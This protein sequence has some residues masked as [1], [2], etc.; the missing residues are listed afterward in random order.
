MT[1][2]DIVEKFLAFE[3]KH[4]HK[5]ISNVS[6][7]PENDPTLLYVNSGMFPLVPYLQG[8]PHPLGKR[9][10]NVQRALRFFEDLDNVG[11]TNRHTTAFHMLGNWSLGDYFKEEQLTWYFEFLVETLGLDI[12]KMYASIFAGDIDAPKDE[13][14]M[15]VLKR[16]FAKYGVSA[17]EGERIFAY[18]KKDNWWKRGEAVG[19]L[20]GPDSEVFYY[21]GESGDGFG[22]NPVENQNDFL[23][24]GNSVFMQY[25]KTE[26]GWEELS[27]KNVDFG[28]GL[29]R[30]ALVLQNKRDIFET[31]NFWPII[32][33][34][35]IMSGKKY[36]VEKAHTKAMRVL[37]DHMR[38][39]VFM[40][41]DGVLPSNREQG[42][43]LRR[44]L[45]RMTRAGMV[46]GIDAKV[47]LSP[48][49]VG[50][51]AE[52]FSWLY[53]DLKNK[54]AL[55][56]KIFVEEESRFE[57]VLVT[58]KREVEKTLTVFTGNCGDLVDE[59]FNLYQSF[60]YPLEIFLEDVN[61]RGIEVDAEG[62][63]IDFKA[64]IKKHQ[65]M[66]REGASQKF[67]GGLADH[68]DEVI[69]YHTVT[70]LLHMALRQV[71]GAGIIQKGSNIT[72]ERLRFDFSYD[73][74]LTDEQI[75]QVEG[76][77]RN[78][79]SKKLPVGFEIMSKT[80]AEKVGALHA[81]DEKYGD[82]VKVY[83]IGEGLHDAIS[84]EFCG[85][86]HVNNTQELKS[87]SVYK[88]KSV[89]EGLQRIYAR[90][91]GLS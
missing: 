6:L 50:V 31:D 88:Q 15:E 25:K 86:P 71:L 75:E 36:G 59:A 32:E 3:K 85:G 70:H 78:A 58:G 84:K 21:I 19:E 11:E 89:G 1:S 8:E 46:L 33:Q 18:G 64:M 43:I 14:S 45:R 55:I 20:G 91:E 82:E 10:T 68:S 5:E 30:L 48:P 35:Q 27:Q 51:V 24:I 38:S 22:R 37:A 44:L 9:L 80:A 79:I 2:R 77:I 23:E 81:F 62:F 65:Q 12:K 57:K 53:P 76:V 29:E 41:M 56:E 47:D 4:G 28:G 90:F 13:E 49:L 16:V 72:K 69:K 74:S 60:G 66:S 52:T 34:V 42:Y 7:I 39:S 83:Y 73:R 17:K 67:K 87:L 63:E 61:D 40:S 54:Q 26:T